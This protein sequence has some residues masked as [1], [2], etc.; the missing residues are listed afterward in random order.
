MERVIDNWVF[1]NGADRY[2]EDNW[3]MDLYIDGEYD[4][5]FYHK[6]VEDFKDYTDEQLVEYVQITV[7]NIQ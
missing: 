3:G 1:K 2:D 6:R 5:S 7:D 4:R